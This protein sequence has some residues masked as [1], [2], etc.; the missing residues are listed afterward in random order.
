MDQEERDREEAALWYNLKM[1]RR[2][3][4]MGRGRKVLMQGQGLSGPEVK[5]T[6]GIW[7]CSG[8]VSG[9]EG[10]AWSHWVGGVCAGKG[11]EDPGMWVCIRK[12]VK[13]GAE[14]GDSWGTWAEPANASQV[15]SAS[16]CSPV[17]PV[18]SAGLV[19][20]LLGSARSDSGDPVN[21]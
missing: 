2:G 16:T 19:G 5:S 21:L 13:W 18:T 11:N 15:S 10:L 17:V 8:G 1:Q 9:S 3:L 6:K 20:K 12:A 4:L 14:R 7:L